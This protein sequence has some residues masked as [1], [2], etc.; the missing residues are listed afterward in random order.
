MQSL[1]NETEPEVWRQI[2]P[3]L[4]D[5]M[6]RLGEKDRDALVLRFFEGKSFQDIA[7]AAGA[8]ENAAKKRVHYALEKLRR[9]FAKRGVVSSASALARGDGHL[10]RP[11][12]A[13][14]AGAIHHR[15]RHCQRGGGQRLNLGAGQGDSEEPALGKNEIRRGSRRR[16]AGGGRCGHAR[17]REYG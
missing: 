1:A 7:S 2:A 12:R 16:P 10:L 15:R 4:E 9:Y 17:R 3:L 8:T 11:G 6:A 14:C 13:D 5:G